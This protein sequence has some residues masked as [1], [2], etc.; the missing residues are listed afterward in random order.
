M[1]MD[2]QSG[3]KNGVDC[4]IDGATGER[5]QGQGNQSYRYGS[6]G[7]PVIRAMCRMG[8]GDDRRI[9]DTTFDDLRLW[10]EDVTL[11]RSGECCS[12]QDRGLSE[13]GSRL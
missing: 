4:G 9:V 1:R 2:Q 8:F 13:L 5:S 3:H 6:F 10:R 7:N 11:A 12:S